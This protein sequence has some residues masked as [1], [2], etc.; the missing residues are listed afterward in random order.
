MKFLISNAIKMLWQQFSNF[1]ACTFWIFS[2]TWDKHTCEVNE[3]RSG[4]WKKTCLL[5]LAFSFVCSSF[6]SKRQK[7]NRSVTKFQVVTLNDAN[8]KRKIPHVSKKV[9]FSS[10]VFDSEGSSHPSP[11]LSFVSSSTTSWSPESEILDSSESLVKPTLPNL[12]EL[13]CTVDIP[14]IKAWLLYKYRRASGNHEAT[15]VNFRQIELIGWPWQVKFVQGP[16][17]LLDII[18]LKTSILT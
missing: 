6:A 5:A 16:W 10:D 18:L 12:N 8:M 14:N 13:D 11:S 3:P 15:E 17:S 4:M 1:L 9:S 7:I 2:I